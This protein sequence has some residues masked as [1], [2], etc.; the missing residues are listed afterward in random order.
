MKETIKSTF[1]E[2]NNTGVGL[3]NEHKIKLWIWNCHLTCISARRYRWP[4][5]S[6]RSWS[7]CQLSGTRTYPQQ[8]HQ[9]PEWHHQTHPTPHSADSERVISLPHLHV[10]DNF[11]LQLEFLRIVKSMLGKASL[12]PSCLS[13][14][15]FSAT[16]KGWWVF[17]F[18]QL[19]LWLHLLSDFN[20]RKSEVSLWK[21]RF[22]FAFG[23]SVSHSDMGHFTSIVTTL[24]R[25]PRTLVFRNT[26]QYYWILSLISVLLTWQRRTGTNRISFFPAA[27]HVGLD[28]AP[29]SKWAI[30]A[31]KSH[32][33]ILG[34]TAQ[35]LRTGV[36]L[37]TG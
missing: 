28:G 18:P 2:R 25:S 21:N 30:S 33:L 10:L 34:S 6:S 17:P 13:I 37:M 9:S 4:C 14:V 23:R 7:H 19:S 20:G 15:L 22:H 27:E 24:T 11:S 8:R 3:E 12:L 5:W 16:T 29:P 26:P 32:V 31:F 1:P 36:I 35:K